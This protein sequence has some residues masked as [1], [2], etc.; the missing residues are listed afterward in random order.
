MLMVRFFVYINNKMKIDDQFTFNGTVRLIEPC[1]TPLLMYIIDYFV[2]YIYRLISEL[3]NLI[4]IG[5]GNR[6]G[7]K[8]K[9]KFKY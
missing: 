7:L 9:P 3:L 8:I 6:V 4:I 2:W 5:L 1:P